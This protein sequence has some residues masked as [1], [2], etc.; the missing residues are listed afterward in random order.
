MHLQMAPTVIIF[1]L[2]NKLDH[3][4]NPAFGVIKLKNWMRKTSEY[5]QN[6][7]GIIV[8]SSEESVGPIM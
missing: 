7:G 4:I 3:G 5:N 1:L 8:N 2:Q 6:K